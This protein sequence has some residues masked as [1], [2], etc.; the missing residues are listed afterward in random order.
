MGKGSKREEESVE[1]QMLV[2]G[3]MAYSI[4]DS[5]EAFNDKVK[6]EERAHIHPWDRK[7][8]MQQKSKR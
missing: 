8:A 6:L 3:L 5:V 7:S 4:G 1:F 2:A